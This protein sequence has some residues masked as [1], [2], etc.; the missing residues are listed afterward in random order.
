MARNSPRTIAAST[1]LALLAGEAAVVDADG[2]IVVIGEPEVVK[3]D[4]GLR[5]GVV[6]DQRGL[7]AF[8]LVQHR[9]D[10]IGR[11][12][13]RPWRQG[14]GHQHRDIGIGA[15]IGM[16]DRAGIGVARQEGG[17]GRRIFDR[18]RQADA[19]Q[20]G[21]RG[22]A[23]ATAPASADRRV[24]FRPGRG[25]HR[26]SPAAARRR[27]AAHPRSWS[28]A[29]G[30]RAWSA[31]YAADRRAGAC[32]GWRWCRRCGPRCGSAGPSRRPGLRRLRWMS[33]ASALSGE[34]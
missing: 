3:E 29:P 20:A 27:C 9:R 11:A 28:A 24:C 1:A 18:G 7:V 30:F 2:Q 33:A 19:P 5:A 22:P 16:Q 31:G 21:A 12:A 14:F 10:G 17:D 26:R 23:A 34:M 15:G 32:A 8:D 6:K 25:F 4:L 13:A